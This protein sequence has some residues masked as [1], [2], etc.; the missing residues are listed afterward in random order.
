[1][2]WIPLW[3][4][5]L[6]SVLP[7]RAQDT[8][9]LPGLRQRL[10][11]LPADTSRVR[12]L[13]QLCYGLHD[14]APTRALPYGEEAVTLAR[15]LHDQP[16]LLYSLLY[17]GSCYANLSDGPHALQLQQ[18]A[19]TL[20]QQLHHADGIVRSYAGMGGIH[21][22]RGDTTSALRNYRLGL[23]HL[24]EPGVSVRTQLMLL[25]NLGGLSFYMG[26][27]ADGLLYT[28]RAMQLAHQH[29]DLSGESVYVGHLGTYYLR[30]ERLDVAEGLL[31]KALTLAETARNQR[32]EASQLTM[33]ATVLLLR[34]QTDEAEELARRALALA[35]RISF[36]ERVLDAYDIMAGVNEVRQDYEQAYGWRQLYVALND[37]LNSQ[38]RLNT[39]SALQTR[40]ETRAKENQIRLLTQRGQLQQL[41]NRVLWAVVATLLLGLAGVGALTWKL[42]RSRQALARHH[43]AL[44]QANA[45]TRR[46][47]ASKDRLY[48]IVA[49]DLRGPVTSF[50]GVT[51]LIDF[52]LRTGDEEGLRRLPTQ[53]R[54]SAQHLNGLLDNLLNWAVTQTGELAYEPAVLPLDELLLQ[55]T[56]LHQ[57]AA[58]ARQITLST[59]A[60]EGL[61]AW[62]D[63]HM[64]GTVLRNLLGNALRF[65]PRGGSIHLSAVRAPTTDEVL[66]Q[67]T[68][69]GSG[70]SPE[71]V[72]A[73][74][75]PE[76]EPARRP[77]GHARSGT[78]LGW[79]LCQA[80]VQRQGGRLQISSRPGLGTTVTF[81][82]P[83][84]KQ[85]APAPV[86]HIVTS[87]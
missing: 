21:H 63:A 16:G 44:E 66:V 35:R 62:A 80:F 55:A 5:L 64:S 7:A 17:L 34:E 77:N 81:S 52:Y 23:E 10:R 33:L 11:V 71:Q 51:E 18:Q 27:T 61:A 8:L 37:T 19:L 74:L 53:V 36:P 76:Q 83:L 32:V 14:V 56:E 30:Q 41:R 86:Q 31:R 73:L 50:V 1:M 13:N 85:P 57:S 70:M 58:E 40:Y 6:G 38:A 69:T 4:L 59:T 46:L 25:G 22:E 29:G 65:T 60:P 49:H 78:G 28:R 26:H 43:A 3:L 79:P 12:T 42:R 84:A 54:Q 48:S 75:H 9:A 82:L 24:R 2:R 45:D 68:D 67:V 15:R 87:A 72:Q 20:A 39:L 47:A